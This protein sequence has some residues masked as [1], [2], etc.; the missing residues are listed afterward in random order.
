MD[1]YLSQFV[2][3]QATTPA[4]TEEPEKPRQPRRD[5][6]LSVSSRVQPDTEDSE[7]YDSVEQSHEPKSLEH[8]QHDY[9]GDVS[10]P[11]EGDGDRPRTVLD[12]IHSLEQTVH[13][14]HRLMKRSYQREKPLERAA[15]QVPQTA[16]R[17]DKVT[18]YVRV[19]FLKIGE[20]DTLKEQYNADAFVQARW[21]EPFLDG[22]REINIDHI[23]WEKYWNPKVYVE[24]SLGEPRESIWQTLMFNRQGEATVCERRRIKGCFLENLELNEF[25]FDTQDLTLTVTSE[26]TEA[27]LVL[28]EDYAQMS[29]INVQSF[30]DEQEWRLHSHVETWKRVSDKVYQNSKYKHPAISASCRASRRPEFFIWN[31]F[32][33]MLFICSLAFATFTVDLERPE[34]RLQLSFIL[35][36]TTITFKFVVSQ[37]LPRIPY[38]TYLDKYILTSMCILCT[39]CVWHS[40]VPLLKYNEVLSKAADRCALIVLW[41]SY[42]LFHICFFAYIAFVAVNKRWMYGEKDKMHK[43]RMKRLQEQDDSESA[44]HHLQTSL[45]P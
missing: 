23:D 40:T 32:L 10:P 2:A 41:T 22:R 13:D 35:L 34:N 44:K 3:L 17:T 4:P 21:R 33:V 20:I 8:L 5:S 6:K 42:L 39:V 14:H 12:A 15:S 16:L 1:V 7:S 28:E 31:I 26:R 25:P 30:V 36:L 9:A 18:V 38:L 29:S 37:N 19:V 24:N 11:V 27:E 45:S 43:E